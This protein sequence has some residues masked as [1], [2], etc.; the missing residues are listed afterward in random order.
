MSVIQYCSDE[1]AVRRGYESFLL[2][3]TIYQLNMTIQT[4]VIH[5]NPNIHF[6]MKTGHKPNISQSTP[7]TI[8][9]V[10]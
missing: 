5:F 2:T 1:C 7:K 4:R 8:E 6:N 3:E 9:K 10:M